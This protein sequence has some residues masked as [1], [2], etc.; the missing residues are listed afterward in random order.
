[1]SYAWLGNSNSRVTFCGNDPDTENLSLSTMSTGQ[2]PLIPKVS[3]R[4]EI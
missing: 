3:F 2:S 1:M 4:L